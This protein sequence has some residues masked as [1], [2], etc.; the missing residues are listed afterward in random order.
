MKTAVCCLAMVGSTVLAGCAVQPPTSAE[1]LATDR[2]GYVRGYLAPEQLPASR[3]FLLPPPA[4]A[5]AAFSADREVYRATRS[6]RDTPR[7]TQAVEDAELGF[8]NAARVFSC[9]LNLDISPEATPHLNMLLRRVRADASRAND[10]AKK[11]YQRQRPYLALGETSCTP[12]KKHKND[13]YPS[14]HSS[15]GWAWALVLAEIAPGQ[16]DAVFARGL[17]LARAG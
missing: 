17:V 11:L 4:A 5:S 10:Q 9:A 7:W 14:G 1:Q 2:P 13:S 8:P 15:I 12:Q 6:L 16:A 3:E